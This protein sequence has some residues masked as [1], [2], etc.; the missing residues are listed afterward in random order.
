MS[1]WLRI[2]RGLGI[3][4]YPSLSFKLQGELHPDT[5][6]ELEGYFCNI[7]GIHHAGLDAPR[8]LVTLYADPTLINREGIR[9]AIDA[10]VMAYGPYGVE[11]LD[12]EDFPSN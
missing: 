1:L 6:Q 2:L 9:R 7:P 8:C 12:W 4:A 11:G 3:D 10:F 5:W